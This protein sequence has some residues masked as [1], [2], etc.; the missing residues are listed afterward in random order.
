MEKIIIVSDLGHFKAYRVTHENPE[1]ESPRVELI[2]CFDSLEAHGKLSDKLSDSAGRF[3]RAGLDKDSSGAG[4]GERHNIKQE[5]KKR[6][7]KLIVE[8]IEALISRNTCKTWY[9]AAGRAINNSIVE[10]L[11]PGT[12]AKLRKNLKSDLTKINRSEILG[13]FT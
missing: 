8:N 12:R 3:K 1:I 7:V 2:K 4:F 5:S 9:L 10:H 11:G 6:Q 13:Y